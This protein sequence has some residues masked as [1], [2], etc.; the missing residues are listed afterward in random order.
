MIKWMFK[1]PRKGGDEPDANASTA[2]EAED[3]L[4]AALEATVGD[5][6]A[7]DTRKLAESIS[8][9]EPAVIEPAKV[10]AVPTPAKKRDPAEAAEAVWRLTK[11][12]R[13]KEMSE[14]TARAEGNAAEAVAQAADAERRKEEDFEVKKAQHA[15]RKAPEADE[16]AGWIDSLE[17]KVKKIT[18][19]DFVEDGT[20]ADVETSSGPSL[21]GD[22]APGDSSAAE[23]EPSQISHVVRD[24]VELKMTPRTQTRD[25]PF[26]RDTFELKMTP[27]AKTRDEPDN[28][29]QMTPRMQTRDMVAMTPRSSTKGLVEMTPRAA[30]RFREEAANFQPTLFYI[31]D[32]NSRVKAHNAPAVPRDGTVIIHD[33]DDEHQNSDEDHDHPEDQ[34]GSES[35]A[36]L[37]SKWNNMG[38]GTGLSRCTSEEKLK[39]GL[40]RTSSVT[41]LKPGRQSMPGNLPS[42]SRSGTPLTQSRTPLMQSRTPILQGRTLGSTVS[43]GRF[44]YTPPATCRS[45]LSSSVSAS[46]LGYSAPPVAGLK[47]TASATTLGMKASDSTPAISKPKPKLKLTPESLAETPPTGASAEWILPRALA[48]PAAAEAPEGSRFALQATAVRDYQQEV[49][50]ELELA[51]PS[52]ALELRTQKV[53]PFLLSQ[54]GPLLRVPQAAALTARTLCRQPLVVI[55]QAPDGKVVASTAVR[56]GS[57]LDELFHYEG[58][59]GCNPAKTDGVSLALWAPTALQVDLVLYSEATTEAPLEVLAMQRG[60]AGPDD[61]VWRIKGPEAWLGKYYSYKVCAS[62]PTS[63]QPETFEVPDPYSLACSA[64]ASRTLLCQELP[65]LDAA[66]RHSESK[67]HF[68][69]RANAVL[70]SMNG[71]PGPADQRH[72]RSLASAGV[73]HVHLS[74]A[75][76]AGGSSG[77]RAAPRGV[78]MSVPSSSFS[79]DLNGEERV[80]EHQRMVSE[81]NAKGLRVV[82]DLESGIAPDGPL[83]VLEKCVPGYYCRCEPDG[84]TLPSFAFE[85]SMMERLIVDSVVSLVVDHKVDGLCFELS[86]QMPLRCA[87]RCRAALNALTLD[88]H[89][90]DGPRVLLYAGGA[91]AG[92]PDAAAGGSA[93]VARAA[94]QR[95][96]ASSGVSAFNYQAHHAM[97][98]AIDRSLGS[99]SKEQSEHVE[100]NRHLA[101][102]ADTM[103]FCM[104]ASLKDYRLLEDSTGRS[105]VHAREVLGDSLMHITTPDEV[106]NCASVLSEETLFDRISQILNPCAASPDEAMRAVWL[107]M[108]VAALSHGVP[109]FRAGDELLQSGLVNRLGITPGPSMRA[110]STGK[111]LEFLRV[112]A[113][114]PLLGLT[115]ARDM[116]DKVEFPGCGESQMPG[117]LV[118]QI[119]NGPPARFKFA[120]PLCDNFE[121]VVVVISLRRETARVPAPEASGHL[122]LHPEQAKSDDKETRSAHFDSE[123][124]ELVV[125]PLSASV[126]VGL[127]PEPGEDM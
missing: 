113:S 120:P 125:P 31:G 52:F 70:Y 51:G 122:Q 98:A 10:A 86:C 67:P 39:P 46:A 69:H 36:N 16:F 2:P 109:H 59:L 26:V 30:A 110:A 83:Q 25:E 72:L 104:V 18:Q 105:S 7:S 44:S 126:F 57:L 94:S 1:T 13:A 60:E 19:E 121:R 54:S 88:E 66:W 107:C 20:K 73:T 34:L 77:S 58:P 28:L 76:A 114:T 124:G 62:S 3:E 93:E 101:E 15:C 127:M 79:S 118:M 65:C 89:G 64:N 56:I 5:A 41:S 17:M 50:Y 53:D 35:V 4:T 8:L 82:V 21:T 116:R 38:T 106:I 68:A 95:E 24:A 47:T 49:Q 12:L 33:S 78:L 32:V 55:A 43:V 112:R 40:S 117:I 9:A 91:S 75:A 84:T 80:L 103:R 111:L 6:I 87:K 102:L 99:R 37:V 29:V 11:Q 100:L 108:A 96:L 81:L 71:Q 63:R 90:V 23:E 14:I 74:S 92:C 42:L 97:I 48:W 45:S 85:R 27:R 115:D 22:S 123:A 61:G 119:R